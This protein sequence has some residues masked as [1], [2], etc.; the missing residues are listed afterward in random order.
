MPFASFDSP[1]LHYA[2]VTEKDST[3]GDPPGLGLSCI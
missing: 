2:A 3:T 1:H